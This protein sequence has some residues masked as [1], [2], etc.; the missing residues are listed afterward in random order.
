MAECKTAVS[1]LLMHWRYC[2]LALSYRSVVFVPVFLSQV[3]VS[4]LLEVSTPAESVWLRSQDH[5]DVP[6]SYLYI[7][8]CNKIVSICMTTQLTH[9]DLVPYAI[10]GHGQ[11]WFRKSITSCIIA[12]HHKLNQCWHIKDLIFMKKKN[13]WFTFIPFDTVS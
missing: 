11:H 8:L 4:D 2:S 5:V 9:W 13:M 12:Q 3:G 7:L 10:V 6:C 1:P